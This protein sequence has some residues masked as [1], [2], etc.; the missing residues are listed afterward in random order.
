MSE[1]VKVI[2]SIYSGK[3]SK[4]REEYDNDAGECNLYREVVDYFS[5]KNHPAPEAWAEGRIDE[6]YLKDK[7]MSYQR[8]IINRSLRLKLGQFS[9]DT[10]NERYCLIDDG[11]VEEWR[12]LVKGVVNHIVTHEKKE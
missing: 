6:S 9:H 10:R 3:D 7:P 1:E 11:A 2:D 12:E 4:T 5:E 8:L